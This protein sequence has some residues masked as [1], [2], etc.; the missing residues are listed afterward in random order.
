VSVFTLRSNEPVYQGKRLTQWLAEASYPKRPA[1]GAPLADNA[2][3]QIGTNALPTI[4]SLLRSRDWVLKPE[5][6][7]F[8]YKRGMYQLMLTT[9]EARHAWALSGCY[10]LGTVAKPLVS[11]VAQAFPRMNEGCQSAAGV[12][13]LSLG[14]DAGAAIPTLVSIV[15]DRHHAGSTRESAAQA[16]GYACMGVPRHEALSAL[17][18]LRA[19]LQET[20]RTV[21]CLVE[22]L[23]GVERAADVGAKSEAG[24]P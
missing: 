20:N 5:L 4:A 9:E 6:N 11:D 24:A 18:D 1:T 12:W 17:E 21:R 23:L 10:L 3:R 7:R 14:A 15:K 8:F 19:C 2:I 13:L 16:L 22:E